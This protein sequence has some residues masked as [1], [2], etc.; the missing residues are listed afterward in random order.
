MFSGLKMVSLGIVAEHKK[1]STKL[2]K[3][4]PAEA[5]AE[6]DG[7]LR[8]IPV[9]L[10]SAGVDGD[11]LEYQ[12][13]ITADLA[14]ECEWLPFGEHRQTAPDI[15]RGEQVII[16]EIENSTDEKYYWSSVGRDS[17][18]RRLETILWAVSNISDPEA[19]VSELNYDNAYTVE[20][21]THTKQITIRTNKNDGEPFSYIIQLNTKDGNFTITDDVGNYVQLDSKNTTIDLTN[22]DGTHFRLKK[23]D[24]FAFA[25]DSMYMKAVNTMEFKCKDFI[26]EAENSMT[27]KSTTY[28][29]TAKT[30]LNKADSITNKAQ[31]ITNDAPVVTCT[32]LLKCAAITAGGGGAAALATM[33][34]HGPLTIFAGSSA[35]FN[36]PIRANAG[37]S[38]T[39]IQPDSPGGYLGYPPLWDI[40]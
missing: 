10:Y 14:L 23:K 31:S 33:G 18:L 16:W 9:V 21:S 37:I 24:I 5:L 29:N 13:N 26:A 25:P 30:M 20:F 3:I 7:E 27:M 36:I 34:G 22:K 17:R 2:A 1:P 40:T 39:T 15:R 32:G 11:N 38:T 4:H 12:V 19:E 28:T 6:I 35:E 8:S